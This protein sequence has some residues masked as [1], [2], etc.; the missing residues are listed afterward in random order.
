[1]ITTSITLEE[2]SNF[3]EHRADRSPN[4]PGR[5]PSKNGKSAFDESKVKRDGDGMFARSAS[6]N[7]KQNKMAGPTTVAGYQ[8]MFAGVPVEE[9]G[10]GDVGISHLMPDGRRIWLYGDTVSKNNGFVHSTAMVQTG[11]KLHVSQGGKQL[12]PN[13]GKDP[14]DPARDL[15]H[16]VDG[17]KKG[18][19]P[20]TLIVSSMQMSIGK[21]GPFDFRQTPTGKSKQA[22]VK[23]DSSGNLKFVKWQG[24]APT[25]TKNNPH[26]AN[27]FKEV[28]PSHYTY[29][30]VTHDIKLADGSNL[31]TTSQNWG[32]GFENHTNPDGSLKYRDWAPMFG[33]STTASRK[34][35]HSI[36]GPLEGFLA[37]H[38]DVIIT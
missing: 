8:K 37:R 10:G 9:W 17:V 26:L 2:M 38:A 33:K 29:G 13:S 3:L 20:N 27:D 35:A 32:D 4:I 5:P 19:K 7:D 18:P 23:V 16:W 22:L 12:L 25:P 15:I 24:W 30:K 21:A 36:Q 28:S 14:A 11:K 1:M 34:I 6:K 31:T